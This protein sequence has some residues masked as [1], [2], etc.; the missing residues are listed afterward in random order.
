[1]SDLF[2]YYRVPDE[3]AAQL[4]PRVLAMQASL[5]SEHAVVGQLKRRP[6]SSDGRQTW[7]EVY[8]ATAPGFDAALAAAV[9]QAAL[10]NFIDGERHTEVFTD[11][12][13]CA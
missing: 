12:S 10:F 2:I 4:A 8:P 11:L 5:A 6:G 9:Q 1:M 3:H 13:T 7:M